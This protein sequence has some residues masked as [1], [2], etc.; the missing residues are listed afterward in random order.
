MEPVLIITAKKKGRKILEGQ[1]MFDLTGG[2]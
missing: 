1:L 2:M